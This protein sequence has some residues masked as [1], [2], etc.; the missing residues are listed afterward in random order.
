[1]STLP[2]M[3]M[4]TPTQGGDAG[5]WDDKINACFALIDAHDHTSGQGVAVPVAG[6][7]IDT[8]LPM[9]GFGFT[10]LGKIS[11]TTIATPSSGSKNLFVDSSDNELY[12]R[13]SGGTNV[14]L[15]SGSTINASL[16]GG[17]GGDYT[18]VGA[19]V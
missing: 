8:N 4:V 19:A 9:G 13:S 6:L 16:I 7:N 17:I 11:F 14:K 1:M 18:A 2:N 10:N 15:T 12:W 5:T 3:G